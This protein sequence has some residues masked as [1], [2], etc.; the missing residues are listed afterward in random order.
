MDMAAV[1]I[2][3]TGVAGTRGPGETLHSAGDAQR[4]LWSLIKV[5]RH[6]MRQDLGVAGEF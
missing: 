5:M 1:A 4:E 6:A 2:A 3:V